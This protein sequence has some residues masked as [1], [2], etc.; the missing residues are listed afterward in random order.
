MAIGDG[1]VAGLIPGPSGPPRRPRLAEALLP[2]GNLAEFER[3]LAAALISA[4]TRYQ[5]TDRDVEDMVLWLVDLLGADEG[6]SPARQLL[7][8]TRPESVA[9]AAAVVN[10]ARR[11]GTMPAR[12]DRWL[13]TNW[14]R[15]PQLAALRLASN[16]EC[17]N[18]L[19]QA[20][21][22]RYEAEGQTNEQR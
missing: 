19:A 18:D 5:S 11:S 15:D 20:A 2:E 21:R 12:I 8:R 4:R 7:R 13:E 10:A 3:N 6:T 14:R 9:L 16:L 1:E 17:A 22:T